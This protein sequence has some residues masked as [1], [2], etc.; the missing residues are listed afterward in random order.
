MNSLIKRF[1]SL[2]L[3]LTLVLSS[4][5]A[6]LAAEV[7]SKEL[8]DLSGSWVNP[9]YQQYANVQT[10]STYSADVATYNSMPSFSTVAKA[11]AYVRDQMEARNTAITFQ[12]QVA[13]DDYVTN[14]RTALTEVA[15]E[16]WKHTGVPTE[17]DYLHW[18]IIRYG[19]GATNGIYLDCD[20]VRFDVTYNF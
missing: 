17:G 1:L 5:P 11:G 3:V 13:S 9:M 10:V 12:Y 4:V 2:F 18:Q 19:W 8:K 7:D 16:A 20:T 6:A 14:L 15:E